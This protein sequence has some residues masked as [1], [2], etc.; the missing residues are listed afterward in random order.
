L[1]VAVVLANVAASPALVHRGAG[2]DASALITTGVIE[3]EASGRIRFAVPMP[4]R[5]IDA[6]NRRAM[7]DSGR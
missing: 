4:G 6:A 3:A 5:T 7:I 2:T 1:P